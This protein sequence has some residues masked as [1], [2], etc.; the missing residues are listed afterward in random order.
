MKTVFTEFAEEKAWKLEK[1][2]QT[3]QKTGPLTVEE[4]IAKSQARMAGQFASI[5]EMGREILAKGEERIAKS[6]EEL[7]EAQ[8]R[9][10][11]WFEKIN[12]NLW[13]IKLT[14]NRKQKPAMIWRVLNAGI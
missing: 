7:R 11:T 8:R 5:H 2:A 6:Q 4:A 12:R 1:L 14:A 9:L 3:G 10:I 13:A